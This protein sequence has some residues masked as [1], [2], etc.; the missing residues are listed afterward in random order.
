MDLQPTLDDFQEAREAIV[1]LI[2]R[3][4]LFSSR[5]LSEKTGL[6]VWL[7]GENFQET[8]SF[9]PRGVFNKVLHL[10]KADRPRGIISASS[11]N[12]GQ[13]A[14][15][16]INPPGGTRILLVS[17]S[18]IGM[19][20]VSRSTAATHIELDPGTGGVC[21]GSMSSLGLR[22]RCSSASW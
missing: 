2:H 15:T 9:K 14:V 11:R 10:S 20:L 19:I 4:P 16:S 6:E 12:S 7:K 21:A 18:R 17:G 22:P 5:S 8:G 1:G 3:T 13:P